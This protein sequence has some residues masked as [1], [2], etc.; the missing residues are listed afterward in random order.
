MVFTAL[1]FVHQPFTSDK[2]DN[3]QSCSLLSSVLTFWA[4]ALVLVANPAACA[5]E[6]AGASKSTL[7]LFMVSVNMVVILLAA[8]TFVMDTAPKMKK[9]YMKKYKKMMK[10]YKILK[11][12]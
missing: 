10:A 3:L 7:G 5:P 4:A 12:K 8:Y 9:K 1:H 11:K 6:V 2:D